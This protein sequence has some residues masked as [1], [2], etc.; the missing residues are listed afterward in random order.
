MSNFPPHQLPFAV[1]FRSYESICESSLTQRARDKG[2][3]TQM[4]GRKVYLRLMETFDR[5]M[6]RQF[7]ALTS[8]LTVF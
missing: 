3:E 8:V 2:L 6:W 4:Q 1:T 7:A 5:Y